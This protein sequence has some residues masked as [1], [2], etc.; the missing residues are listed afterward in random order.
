MKKKVIVKKPRP[1][2]IKISHKKAP[3]QMLV[4]KKAFC[5]D[6]KWGNMA[7]C[8]VQ[9]RINKGT[10]INICKSRLGVDERKCRA[11]KALVVS[12]EDM[13]GTQFNKTRKAFSH[14]QHDFSYKVG[15]IVVADDFCKSDA[16]CAAGIH[17]FLN[18]DD[19]IAYDLS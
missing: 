8:L 16:K 10:L 19:A 18:K 14:H 5:L 15:K 7:N 6:R 12:I 13:T 11:A 3:R 4:W 2:A 9:L 17:F 1:I